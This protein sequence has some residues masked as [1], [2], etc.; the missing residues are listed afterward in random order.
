MNLFTSVVFIFYI[1]TS[2]FSIGESQ[3]SFNVVDFG[4]VGD[5]KTDDSTAFWKAW[6]AV[7]EA[8][9]DKPTLAIPYGKTFLIHSTRFEGPCKSQN[10]QIQILGNIIAPESSK[11][12]TDSKSKCWLCFDSIYGLIMQGSGTIDGQGSSWWQEKKLAGNRP[13]AM[14]FNDCNNF[15]LSGF[16]IRNSPNV[17]IAINYCNGGSI[18]NIHIN[19]PDDSPNTDGINISKSKQI[20]IHDSVI[21]SGDD[22]VAINGGSFNIN[23]T[24]IACGPG[25][26]ISIGSLGDNGQE[27]IVE[28]VHVQNCSLNGTQNGVRIKTFQNGS[29]Y[30]RKISFEEI[31]LINCKNPII[32]DQNYN[33]VHHRKIKTNS[34]EVSAVSFTSVYGTSAN[35]QAITLDCSSSP[36]CFN[37]VMNKINIT[38]SAPGKQTRAYCK[39]AYGTSSSTHP[40]VDCLSKLNDKTH[41]KNYFI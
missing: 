11:A 33:P 6:K 1:I 32:I 2:S 18:S 20:Y 24:G 3:S 37:I 23:V 9:G 26:G 38:S 29:G 35:E 22:C 30:A 34:L 28:E 16:T 4:A 25:H 5:G 39:N 27:D 15:Y 40:A 17:H 7:C 13:R 41:Q 8:G 14:H 10:V 36:G 12:R 31:T 19:S 21:E